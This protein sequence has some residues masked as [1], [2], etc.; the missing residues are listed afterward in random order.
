MKWTR[1]CS[2]LP[3]VMLVVLAVAM[4]VDTV[5]ARQFADVSAPARI[6]AQAGG[7]ASV[8]LRLA[9]VDGQ[10]HGVRMDATLPD[11]WSL[12]IPVPRVDIPATGVVRQLI[13]IQ[14]PSTTTGGNHSV[15]FRIREVGGGAEQVVG[16]EV[17]V[18]ARHSVRVEPLDIPERVRAGQ[19]IDAVFVLQ[20]TGNAPADIALEPGSSLS[21]AVSVRPAL[22]RL[23]PGARSD[24]TVSVQ[25]RDDLTN[26]ITHVVSLS[27]AV[28]GV[29]PAVRTRSS[30]T[31]ELVPVRRLRRTDTAGRVPG[32][33]TLQGI[34][35]NGAGTTGQLEMSIPATKIGTSVVSALVRVPDVRSS[36]S[37]GRGDAYSFS[38]ERT[39]TGVRLGDQTYVVS[40]LLDN[41][42][43]GFGAEVSHVRG[44]LDVQGFASR[45]RRVFPETERLGA[46]IHVRP[47]STTR[48]EVNGLVRRQYEPG[49]ALSL[50]GG[51][52]PVPGADVRAEWATGSYDT[53]SGQAVLVTAS[54]GTSRSSVTLR[55]EHA[56]PDFLGG[57]QN[58]DRLQAGFILS[59][60]SWFRMQGQ[61]SAARRYFERPGDDRAVLDTRLARM[62][63]GGSWNIGAQRIQAMLFAQQQDRTVSETGLDRSE[64]RLMLRF[65]YNR[66]GL[67]LNGQVETGRIVD[68]AFTEAVFHSGQGSVFHIVGAW[69]LSVNASINDGPTF[70]SPISQRRSTVGATASYDAGR[71]LRGSL[72]AF[73]SAETALASQHFTLL[74]GWVSRT[75]WAGHEL[76]LRAR[77]SRTSFA[78]DVRRASLSLSYRIPFSFAAPGSGSGLRQ[79]VELT[80]YSVETG[81]PLEGVELT[82]GEQRFRTDAV[83]KVTI[84]G[85]DGVWIMLSAASIG[86]DRLPLVEFPLL[87]N[88]DVAPD[89]VLSVGV[90]TASN[91][92]VSV[93]ADS[94]SAGGADTALEAALAGEAGAGRVVEARSGSTRIRRMTDR[95][96]TAVFPPLVPGEWEVFIVG[97]TIP[98]G[99]E[100][101][102]DTLTTTLLS[103]REQRVEL[104]M[105]PRRRAI[106]FV[107]T[108]TG[109]SLGA[110]VRPTP[111]VTDDMPAD[112]AH[113]DE[114]VENPSALRTV[115]VGAGD[116]LA[117]LART[118]YGTLFHWIR[119]WQANQQRVPDPELLLPGQVLVLPPAGPLTSEERAA[120]L[121]I[122][123]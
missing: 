45:S 38:L 19:V 52:A 69:T 111:A 63:L 9:S 8:L 101:I 121:G 55:A 27:A 48:V 119:I 39:R 82:S 93:G 107:T 110:P 13:S 102:P 43:L 22:L 94:G 33:L 88:E 2:V 84:S 72:S 92:T 12:L 117:G 120:L 71:S 15:S 42:S 60:G 106:Q 11:G 59:K 20:N 118:H 103:G 41:S 31:T 25:T 61:G 17:Y 79:P 100:A 49:E 46:R 104:G 122:G 37:Y 67:G 57:I 89:G 91:L 40:E 4:H 74:D 56:S 23:E 5:Q 32:T 28:I 75:V 113:V 109:L 24:V 47:S 58:S 83:G 96:G 65:G 6:E 85:G 64:Q 105:R 30:G 95:T 99:Y 53:G 68:P 80:F 26:E 123:G 16:F 34:S 10:A 44:R 54:G 76:E 62:G 50:A 86:F 81:A 77:T 112:N 66:R 90:V 114:P 21:Y 7:V 73:R 51:W 87:L 97:S 29:E 3:P 115:T 78:S 35:E 36:S 98:D 1:C 116:T 108:G 14:I 70:Y 18:A